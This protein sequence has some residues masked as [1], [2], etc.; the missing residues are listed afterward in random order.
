MLRDDT[1]IFLDAMFAQALDDSGGRVNIWTLDDKA[2]RWFDDAAAAAKY[3][4]SRAKQTN[5]YYGVGVYRSGITRGRGKVAD[6]IAMPCLWADVDVHVPG[7]HK[8]D[9]LPPDKDAAME[10]LRR[11]GVP[12]SYVIDSGYGLQAVWLL[13]EAIGITTE[14]DRERCET[15]ARRWTATLWSVAHA[16]GWHYDVSTRDLTRI[17]RPPGTMNHKREPAVPTR[18]VTG[19][20]GRY[21]VDALEAVMVAEIPAGL[22]EPARKAKA[23]V[24]GAAGAPGAPQPGAE[25][26]GG[27]FTVNHMAKI[28]ADLLTTLLDVSDGFRRAWGLTAAYK[29]G[30]Q[31]CSTYCMAIASSMADPQ[32]RLS[33]QQIV[34]GVSH[35]MRRW[36]SER[37]ASYD[38]AKHPH[39]WFVTLLHKARAL[40]GQQHAE[41]E[42]DQEIVH[43]AVTASDDRGEKIRWL[44]SALGVNVDAWE[45]HGTNEAKYYI[46]IDGVRYFAGGEGCFANQ[47]KFRN[48]INAVTKGAVWWRIRKANAWDRIAGMLGQVVTFIDDGETEARDVVTTWLNDYADTGGV[49][50]EAHKADAVRDKIGF[51]EG[52]MVHITTERLLEHL[53]RSPANKGMSRD[54]VRN[55]LKLARFEP[56]VIATSG[57]GRRTTRQYWRA[58]IDD[59]GLDIGAVERPVKG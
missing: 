46:K 58:G 17:L 52:G 32:L 14:A 31:S 53:L 55:K 54:D 26:E 1:S 49:M 12:A 29:S 27:A 33:N 56:V 47:I 21:S 37:D 39:N 43:Q 9:R 30:D 4:R 5:V 40:R 44:R 10:L 18:I 7:L 8:D 57:T 15:L 3:A 28:D 25:V 51:V 2:S 6:V 45:Q 13:D 50:P 34:D 20:G 41:E 22:Y 23:S 42:A 11:V 35:F 36:Q 48:R 59:S 38:P 24:P 16:A 19:D